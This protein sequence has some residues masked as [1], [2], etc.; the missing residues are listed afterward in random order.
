MGD[1]RDEQQRIRTELERLRQERQ[2]LAASLDTGQAG[3]T[4]DQAN[5]IERAEELHRVDRRIGALEDRLR[6]VTPA[7]VAFLP[8][9]T[10]VVLRYADGASEHIEVGYSAREESS[11]TMITADSPLA[12]ALHGHGPGDAIQWHTPS[13]TASAELVSVAVP[14][15]R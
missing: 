6:G 4:A 9:G 13:G 8:I 5:T 3:D 2:E 11:V 15:E 7:G 12:R 10:R 1:L 14:D